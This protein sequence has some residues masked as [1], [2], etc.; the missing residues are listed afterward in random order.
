MDD[1][2][3]RD[4]NGRSVTHTGEV[5][6]CK[7]GVCTH[8]KTISDEIVTLLRE[9]FYRNHPVQLRLLLDM[10]MHHRDELLCAMCGATGANE[11]E[12]QTG[13][14]YCSEKCRDSDNMVAKLAP[15]DVPLMM[16][17][18]ANGRGGGGSKDSDSK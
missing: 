12:W 15:P 7:D 16:L 14:L 2:W 5:Y 13:R 17:N 3:F 10:C 8:L 11:Y 4:D 1:V 6:H 18:P 9:L